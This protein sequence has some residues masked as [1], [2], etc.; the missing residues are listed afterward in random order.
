MPDMTRRE[1]ISEL[2]KKHGLKTD[3][4]SKAESIT[5]WFPET[6]NLPVDTLDTLEGFRGEHKFRNESEKLN[7]LIESMKSRGYDK[8][9]PI[10]VEVSETGKP[11]IVEGNHRVAAAKKSGIKDIP[12]EIKYRGGSEG[13]S[14]PLS[15]KNLLKMAKKIAPKVAPKLA[16]LAGGPIGWGVA[17]VSTMMDAADVYAGIESTQNPQNELDH[18]RQKMLAD[19]MRSNGGEELY[20]KRDY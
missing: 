16:A 3:M 6:V 17:G 14:G 10:L 20:N 7:P 12:V 2:V 8:D 18:S 1:A 5:G 13:K 19:L 9:S 15:A 11:R 4:A